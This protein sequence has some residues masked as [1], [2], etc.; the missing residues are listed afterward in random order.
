MATTGRDRDPRQQRSWSW[1]SPLC[2]QQ[3]AFSGGWWMIPVSV[4]GSQQGKRGWRAAIAAARAFSSLSLWLSAAILYHLCHQPSWRVDVSRPLPLPPPRRQRI[5]LVCCL[6]HQRTAESVYHHKS[7]V[8][9]FFFHKCVANSVLPCVYS[10]CVCQETRIGAQLLRGCRSP[11]STK[12]VT[13]QNLERNKGGTHHS[14]SSRARTAQFCLRPPPQKTHRHPPPRSAATMQMQQL[15][16]RRASAGACS[17][18][19]S[20]LAS[21]RPRSSSSRRVSQR[22]TLVRA[23]PDALLF[24]C[25]GGEC[26]CVRAEA[27]A[28]CSAASVS[29]VCLVCGAVSLACNCAASACLGPV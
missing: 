21:Q 2:V 25:D 11:R 20:R 4:G 1:C 23:L 8:P 6:F 16:Q 7:C 12:L 9:S 5:V 28:A 29:S 17:S 10:Y 27:A 13:Q 14:G 22:T 26:C 19:S 15:S 24:D 18:S 3:S